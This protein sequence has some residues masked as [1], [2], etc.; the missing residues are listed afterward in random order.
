MECW[1]ST[2]DP[3]AA[4]V[5]RPNPQLVP[6]GRGT[7]VAAAGGKRKILG[8]RLGGTYRKPLTAQFPPVARPLSRQIL[9]RRAWQCGVRATQ[10][11]GNLPQKPFQGALC[12]GNRQWAGSAKRHFPASRFENRPTVGW[13]FQSLEKTLQTNRETL[14]RGHSR[15]AICI[16]FG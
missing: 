16:V 12:E 15:S 11:G 1:Q 4:W 10:S 14:F 7:P 8:A 2:A 13:E 6:S 5:R 3:K 9:G